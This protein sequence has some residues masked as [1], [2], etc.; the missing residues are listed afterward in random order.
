MKREAIGFSVA[1]AVAFAIAFSGLRLSAGAPQKQA[2]PTT[3]DEGTQQ[4]LIHLPPG[5]SPR[6]IVVPLHGAT[7]EDAKAD[8][9][10][11][12]TVPMW[13]YTTTS[14]RD[15][16][17]Y[18]G[19]MVGASPFTSPGTPTSVPTQIVPLIIHM[20]SD[21]GTLD[22]TAGDPCAAAPLTNTSDLSLLLNS[23]ILTSHAFTMNGVNIGSTQYVDAFQRA[24][25]WSLVGGQNYRVLINPTTL[26]AVTVDVPVASGGTFSGICGNVGIVDFSF[27]QNYL[28]GTLIPSLVGQGVNS[29]TFPLFFLGN[30]VIADPYVGSTANCCVLGFHSA[31]GS[32][33]QTYGVSDFDT[34]R[35]FRGTADVSVI[36]HEVGE[37]VDDPLG[38]NL[39]P[40]WGHIGQ[41]NSCQSN[42]EVGDPLSGTLFPNAIMPNGYTYHLQELAF[43]S[44]FLGSP[45]LAAGGKFSNNGTFVGQAHSPCPPGGTNPA[46]PSITSQP[47]SQ[48]IA[49]GTAA[50]MSVAASGTGGAFTYQ[51]YVGAS[52]VTTNPIGG[53][54]SSSYTTPALRITTSY[55]VSVKDANGT[56]DSTTATIRLTGR[57]TP[58]APDF[59]GDGKTDISVFRPSTGVWYTVQSG[60]GFGTAFT[61]GGVGD[62]PV[63]GDYDG[64]GK[65]DVAVFRPSTGVW[66]IV[67]SSTGTGFT[68]TWGGGGDIP[69]PGDYDGDGKTDIAVFRPSTGVWFIVLS[70]TG[71]GVTYTWGGAGDIPVTGDY[72]GDGKTDVAVFR[73]STGVWFVIRSS[74]A[75]GFSFTWGGNG[76][77]PVPGDYDG[78]GKTDIAVFRPSTGVWFIVQSSTSTGFTFTWGG[79]GDIP[80]PGDYD[81][82]GKTDIAIFRPSTGVWF[83]VRSSTSTGFTYTWG[84]SGDI[85]I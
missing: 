42:L 22:P 67:L 68:F 12:S 55:W 63:A 5:A 83:V 78:D 40:L 8:I 29:T 59:D 26:P 37:W 16:L 81:G 49:S 80:V 52:G 7:S 44:W 43:F 11:G 69:V 50:T 62:I 51:W 74:T 48:V 2:A 75:T 30:V 54:T 39:V 1:F 24:G 73:P 9:A 70:S 13:S 53:A 38:T 10:A 4:A 25:F 41:Q 46:P 35:S 71:T 32:P 31:F 76:D 23:P 84:G 28:E 45:S 19:T 33:V 47:A 77:I 79:A 60:S 34:S 14:S 3:P 85:P 64:D 36:A 61:W 17:S 15:G 58:S 21:G 65:A 6:N 82:D 57:A 56:A 20:L 72:D 27:I 66:Y 18:S